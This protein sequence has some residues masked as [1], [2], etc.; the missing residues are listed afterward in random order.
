MPTLKVFVLASS[1]T[2]WLASF[3]VCDLGFE[4]E[5]LFGQF[6]DLLLGAT[7]HFF[8]LVQPLAATHDFLGAPFIGEHLLFML[9]D[10][11]QHNESG[12]RQTNQH[13]AKEEPEGCHEFC[14][15]ECDIYRKML[16][17][18]PKFRHTSN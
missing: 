11:L 3:P 10:K 2:A 17:F 1:A 12:A 6:G 14:L 15:A 5:L 4:F 13:G 8:Q 7:G 9:R 16:K 18:R